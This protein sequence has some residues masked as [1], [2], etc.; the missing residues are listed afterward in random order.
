VTT[1]LLQAVAVVE[2]LLVR[3]LTSPLAQRGPAAN[4][5]DFAVCFYR[6]VNETQFHRAEDELSHLFPLPPDFMDLPIGYKA[7]SESNGNEISPC[8]KS[9][10]INCE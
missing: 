2:V 5:K 1:I 7:K 4:L 10:F 6:Y 9:I 3:N 8:F